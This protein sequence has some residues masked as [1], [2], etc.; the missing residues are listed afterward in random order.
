MLLAG[1]WHLIL[2]KHDLQIFAIILVEVTGWAGLGRDHSRALSG[3]FHYWALCYKEVYHAVMVG[4][5]FF[6]SWNASR[7]R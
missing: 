7:K 4:L 6:A 3:T 1:S 5:A 2:L